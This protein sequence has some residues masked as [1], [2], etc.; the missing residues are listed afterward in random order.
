[1]SNATLP[2]HGLIAQPAQEL[3]LSIAGVQRATLFLFIACSAFASIEPSPYEILFV[4]AMAVFGLRELSFD[5]SFIPMI[6]CLAA[7]N[8]G[9]VLSLI[10]FLDDHESFTFIAISVYIAVTAIFFAGLIAKNPL[11]HMPTIRSG[12]I[13]AG[14]VASCF[15]V[16]GYFNIGG[17]AEHFTLYGRASGTFK[18]PNVLGPFLAPPLVWLAQDIMLKRSRLLRSISPMILMLTALLL[19]FSR[20]AWGVWVASTG[21]MIGLT[22]VTT[23]SSALRQR[24][25][26]L[27]ILG[28]FGVVVLLAG[29]LS[30]PAVNDVFIQRASLDQYYDVGEMGRF[31]DQLRS[32][33]MLLV[34]PFGFGPLQYRNHFY[35]TDPH[36]VYINAFASYGWIGG[37]FFAVFTIATI[38]IGWRLVFQRTPFQTEGIAVW[39]CLFVQ[40]LQGFQ[41]DTDHWRHLFLLFG[42]AFG[43]AAASRIYLLRKRKNGGAAISIGQHM[44]G[45]KTRA[46][47][48]TSAGPPRHD[49]S[50]GQQV[51][52]P[53]HMPQ[54][55]YRRDSQSLQS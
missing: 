1:V 21:L 50:P 30:I 7:F 9:G 16:I 17:L 25:V 19:S 47:I 15:A 54:F 40:M 55:V 45:R 31:G 41:I 4:F 49:T 48:K 2:K 28:S 26:A 33:P 18:D 52:K 5:R 35:G 46:R 10:P 38:Y 20:G 29:A 53:K 14:C 24:I 22:F 32:L 3:R 6:L 36:N 39:S 37:L 34:R 42:A 51:A 12:Y 8:A 23:H 11:R 43:L 27:S 13:A 44:D